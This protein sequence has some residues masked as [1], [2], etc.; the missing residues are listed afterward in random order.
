MQVVKNLAGLAILLGV[1]GLGALVGLGLFIFG[2]SSLFGGSLGLISLVALAIAVAGVYMCGGVLWY[3]F[4]N[5]SWK[6]LMAPDAVLE[7]EHAP[8][9]LEVQLDKATQRRYL[10]DSRHSPRSTNPRKLGRG[11]FIMQRKRGALVEEG[12]MV[13][14]DSDGTKIKNIREFEDKIHFEFEHKGQEHTLTVAAL[15]E[16]AANFERKDSWDPLESKH[17]TKEKLAEAWAASLKKN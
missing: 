2:V 12:A 5:F 9:A 6:E 7:R 16:H 4:R 15:T 3:F 8:I 10:I 17:D 14:I 11:V 13:L 1:F